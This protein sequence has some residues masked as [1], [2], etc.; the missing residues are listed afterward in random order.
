MVGGMPEHAE[1]LHSVF[2]RVEQEGEEKGEEDKHQ[3]QG[4][5]EG[6]DTG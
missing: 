1:S 2:L 3:R 4:R 5:G 6:K